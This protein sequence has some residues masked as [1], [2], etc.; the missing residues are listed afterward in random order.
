MAKA[1]VRKALQVDALSSP[2]KKCIAAKRTWD[3][4]LWILPILLCL[5]FPVNGLSQE[6][7]ATISGTVTDAQGASVPH[8]AVTATEVNTGTSS[9]ATT[10]DDGK[11]T[12]PFL[13]PGNYQVRG[14]ASTFE[15]YLRQGI[16]LTA[17]GSIVVDMQLKV[18]NS[19]QTVTVIADGSA[20]QRQLAY[21][22]DDAGDGCCIEHRARIQSTLQ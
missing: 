6:F 15:Q 18:G 20:T 9:T 5:I 12:I 8:A 2:E 19:T 3:S 11:Y 22:P 13:A 1:K 17:G 7:R 4:R 14:I 16:T 10:T 21:G